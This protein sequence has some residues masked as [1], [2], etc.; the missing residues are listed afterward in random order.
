LQQV[1]EEELTDICVYRIGSIQI[2]AFILEKLKNGN[3]GGLHT[4]A[5]ET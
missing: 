5:I 2:D 3:Y 4:K 1:L